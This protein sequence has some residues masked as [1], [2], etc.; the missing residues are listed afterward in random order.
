MVY[1]QDAG[2]TQMQ[3]VTFHASQYL[4]GSGA[5]KPGDVW[6]DYITNTKYGA[7]MDVDIVDGLTATELNTY[8]DELITYEP[9]GGGSATQAR[10]RINGVLDTGQNVLSNLDQIMLSCDSWN[11][12]N[13]ATGKWAIVINKARS[14][15]FAFDDTNIIGE[16]R[17]SAFDISQSI[18]QIEAQFPNNLNLHI[19]YN[20]NYNLYFYI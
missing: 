4:F 14:T 19:C 13:A 18:N 1:S 9:N 16:I 12:Y 2:T 17:V 20:A 15:D 6:Y 5:A 3:A 7:A 10:Y 8:S 11:Q